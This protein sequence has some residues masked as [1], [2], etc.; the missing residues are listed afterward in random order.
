[1]SYQELHPIHLIVERR[2]REFGGLRG[3]F[4]NPEIDEEVVLSMDPSK[5]RE[6]AVRLSEVDRVLDV[7]EAAQKKGRDVTEALAVMPRRHV[8][9][10]GDDMPWGL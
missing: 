10:S 3:W 1:M 4:F 7:L 8:P 5:L 9:P 6:I 2:E